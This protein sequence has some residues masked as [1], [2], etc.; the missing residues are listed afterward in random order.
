MSSLL[1]EGIM[2]NQTTTD[3]TQ[4]YLNEIGKSPLLTAKQEIELAT[5]VQ[6]GDQLARAKMIESNLRLVVKIARRYLN[7][8]LALLDLIEEGN[9]G[10][11][12]AV[13]KFDPTKGFR[14]STYATYWIQQFV[15]RGIMNQARTI[16]LPVHVVKEL[17]T[18]LRASRELSHNLEHE[19]T[20]EEIAQRVDCSIEDVEKMLHINDSTQAIDVQNKEDPTLSLLDTLS[21][22][23]DFDPCEMF[24]D[25]EIKDFIEQWLH[26][27]SDRHREVLAKRYG[28][29]GHEPTTLRRVSEEIGLTRERIRQIQ[30]DALKRLRV[31]L[32]EQGFNFNDLP[33]R[34]STISNNSLHEV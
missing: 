34:Y 28:L 33:D 31:M 20:A 21:N 15:E 16:R 18:Y 25:T 2:G 14:F 17:N 1:G 30:V 24:N 27:L 12:R 6:V 4:L 8:G 23:N 5:K 7:R 26:T 10:L 32:D 29:L 19:P 9:L 3:S 11:I 13:E 22:D